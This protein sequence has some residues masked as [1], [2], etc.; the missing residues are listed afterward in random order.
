M[1]LTAEGAAFLDDGRPD[2]AVEVL[3]R[4]VATGDP[5]APDLLIRAYLE[6]GHWNCIVDW[7]GPL[8]DQGAV[9]YAS[10]LGVA[11]VELGDA[12]RAEDA[13][14]AALAA[15]E[16]A[17]ANDLAILLCGQDRLVE[18][19]GL[20]ADAARD[21]DPQAGANLSSVLLESG[22][23]AG[24]VEAAER[25][26]DESR[27]DTLVALADARVAQDRVADAAT[28]YER[29]VA[30]GG[31]MRA[32]TAYAGFLLDVRGDA[33]GCERELRAAGEAGEPGCA[34]NLGRFLVEIGRADEGRYYLA[35]AAASGDASAELTL[36]ELD[37]ED[38]YED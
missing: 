37:G 20:L 32:H 30:L 6:S 16:T 1:T 27:P 12:E 36:T 8:V 2:E 18:A 17:A 25:H 9:R 21:G 11:L 14:R 4:A 33:D 22:D 31:A 5:A 35:L 28:L 7:L 24:A 26:L 38:P 3:R 19:V 34:A 13:F 15:G 10:R 23:L 29:A